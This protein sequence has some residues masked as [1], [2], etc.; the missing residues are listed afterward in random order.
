MRIRIQPVGLD[1]LNDLVSAGYLDGSLVASMRTWDAA[2]LLTWTPQSAN[3]TYTEDG[4]PVTCV[5]S[6][7]FNVAADK[8]PAPANKDC[9]P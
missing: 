4:Q 1:V 5:S 8:T 9:S 7:N 2:P 3:L 6:T